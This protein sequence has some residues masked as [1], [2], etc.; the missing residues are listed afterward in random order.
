M[1]CQLCGITLEDADSIAKGI[2]PVCAGKYEKFLAAGTNAV[3][4]SALESLANERIDEILTK[5]K[6]AVAA[7][8]KAD[9]AWAERAIQRAEQEARFFSEDQPKAATSV[10]VIEK[11]PIIIQ[12]MSRGDYEYRAPFKHDAFLNEFKQRVG[13]PFRCWNTFRSS[14]RISQKHLT[15][16]EF[17]DLVEQVSE[18][19]NKHFR[20]HVAVINHEIEKEAAA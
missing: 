18:I 17:I 8:G 14:W 15:A 20:A 1:K 12:K 16:V 5:A 6:R 4:I 10:L 13:E 7:G 9:I 19:I 11:T 2:G 3:R